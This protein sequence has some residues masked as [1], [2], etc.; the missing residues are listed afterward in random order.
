MS[1]ND[2]YSL[3]EMADMAINDGWHPESAQRLLEAA[4]EIVHLRKKLAEEQ[5]LANHLGSALD[6]IGEHNNYWPRE[7][8]LNG[9]ADS[10]DR[11]MQHFYEM[12]PHRKKPYDTGKLPIV[13]RPHTESGLGY[14]DE[15]SLA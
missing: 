15:G 9:T 10:L 8:R 7:C 4:A 5:Q 12:R 3:N 6:I 13:E 11:A 14:F 2:P 1:D